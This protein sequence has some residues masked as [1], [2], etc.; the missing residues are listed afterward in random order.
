MTGAAIFCDAAHQTAFDELGFVIVPLLT[1]EEAQAMRRLAESHVPDR[2]AINDPQGGMYNSLFDPALE[3]RIP[4]ELDKLV[5]AR[6][7][8]LVE[9]YRSVGAF[10]MAK[11]ANAGR[12]AL[13][14]HQ[15]ETSD[16]HTRVVHLWLTLQ[17]VDHDSGALRVVP[18][19]QRILRHVQSFRSQPYFL[20]FQQELEEDFAT[21]V[22]MRAGEAIFM[23]GSLLH[24]SCPNRSGQA[25]LR[26]FSVLLPSD[27]PL[28]I[29]AESEGHVF[30]AYAVE[31]MEF[32]P[33]LLCICESSL[34][35]LEHKG[36]LD[37][38][39][40]LLTRQ[41]FEALLNSSD[42]IAPGLDP[43]DAVRARLAM[44]A[45]R[46]WRARLSGFLGWCKA[47]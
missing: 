40:E 25:A 41:E 28:C 24:G 23:D 8:A 42:R 2:P 43:I 30:D 39:N 13:H 19:S 3:R 9:G 7:G 36:R 29:L 32:D 22:P 6:I 35:G 44:T 5:K 12:L 11:V 27:Q 17:D 34:D 47:A 18:R 45:A 26:V 1:S 16:I 38:R 20:G 14:Q 46:G 33:A 10:I 37:N 21:V 31:G 4:A 15:P